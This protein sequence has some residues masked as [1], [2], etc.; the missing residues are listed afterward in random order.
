MSE[1]RTPDACNDDRIDAMLRGAMAVEPS[2]ALRARVRA[3]IADER[4]APRWWW[5]GRRPA[6]IGAVA[7]TLTVAVGG[8]QRWIREAPPAAMTASNLA[9]RPVALASDML[10]PSIEMPDGVSPHRSSLPSSRAMREGRP[11]DMSR[12]EP[13]FDP[14]DRLA[15]ERFLAWS[16]SAMLSDFTS[17]PLATENETRDVEAIEIPAIEVLPLEAVS[18]EE[19]VPQP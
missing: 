6:A 4:Q 16:R 12:A 19:G 9:S 5:M 15:F 7:L 14:R 13:E 17:L 8:W 1:H 2:P 11:V 10:A 3:R 18:E